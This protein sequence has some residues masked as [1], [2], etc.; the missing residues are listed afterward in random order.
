MDATKIFDTITADIEQGKELRGVILI[1][2]YEDG[3][4]ILTDGKFGMNDVIELKNAAERVMEHY[5]ECL[6]EAIVKGEIKL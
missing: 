5:I 3:T 4:R 6:S 1:V 2:R